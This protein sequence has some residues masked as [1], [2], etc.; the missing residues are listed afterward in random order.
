LAGAAA[1]SV[2][3]R[4]ESEPFRAGT[5]ALGAE[6]VRPTVLVRWAFF[7]SVLTIPFTGVYVP[8]TGEKVGVLRIVQ[9]LM[10]CAVLTQPR[11]CLR[12]V[13]TTLFVFLAYIGLRIFWGFWLS[14]DAANSWW[15]NSREFIEFL[16]WFWIMFNVMQFPESRRAGLWA[17]GIGCTLCAL[18]HIAGIGESMV[19]DGLENRSSVFGV[20]ANELGVAYAIAVIAL[21]GLWLLRPRT[22]SQWLLPFPMI[23]IIGIGMAKTGSRSSFLVL[24]TGLWL[25]LV[26]GK[27]LGT[28]TARA[29]TTVM[30]GI[31]VILILWRIPTV[32]ERFHEINPQNIGQENP[33]ARMA[34]VLW[35][36]YLRSPVYGLGPDNYQWELT[37]RAMPYL[38]NH[39]KL[40]VSHNLVL[41]LLVETGIIGFLVFATGLSIPVAAAWKARLGRFGSLPLA[42]LLPL[43]LAG[44]TVCN[45]SHYMVF[46]FTTAFALAS[47]S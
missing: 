15:P 40:I 2:P 41:L 1:S 39:G 18:C 25:L 37:R 42:L 9:L 30:L 43:V 16:P 10:V 17:L 45:P 6:Y 32:L 19:S 44:I 38:I 20:N 34:P 26:L 27:A 14:P 31:V 23:I 46:W 28:R 13:P 29:V 35:E 7:L 4:T 8:G 24:A 12:W 36:M 21:L 11:V 5:E 3:S 22:T 47:D 33:R